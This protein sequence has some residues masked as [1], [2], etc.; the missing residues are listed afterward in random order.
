MRYANMMGK[1]ESLTE[2]AEKYRSQAAK[3]NKLAEAETYGRLRDQLAELA[4]QYQDLADSML[5]AADD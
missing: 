1:F 2:R 5:Q 3:L 4:R